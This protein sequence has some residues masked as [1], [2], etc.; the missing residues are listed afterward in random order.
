MNNLFFAQNKLN[1]LTKYL[2][3]YDNKWTTNYT[4]TDK[5]ILTLNP[6][7]SEEIKLINDVVSSEIIKPGESNG[8]YYEFLIPYN[9]Y[10]IKQYKIEIFGLKNSSNGISYNRSIETV[11][12]TGLGE[13]YLWTKGA[14][15]DGNITLTSSVSS[16]NNLILTPDT[17]LHFKITLLNPQFNLEMN[18]KNDTTGNIMFNGRFICKFYSS[19]SEYFEWNKNTFIIPSIS[20]SSTW[21]ETYKVSVEDTPKTI[22]YVQ[23]N[24]A[25]W[26]DANSMP[27]N[28]NCK[29]KVYFAGALRG[30]VE[31]TISNG[32]LTM[33]DYLV[34]PYMNI[35]NNSTITVDLTI[36]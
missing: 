14:C 27:L 4:I 34:W 20:A 19:I 10:V 32:N 1:F 16:S 26:L 3:V 9:N 5:I 21:T 28:K 23:F 15:S 33:P 36:S 12:R 13:W 2:L 30:T 29:I 18:V 8:S 6:G 24:S 7:T 35:N 11:I 17:F 25:V 31:T 22:N